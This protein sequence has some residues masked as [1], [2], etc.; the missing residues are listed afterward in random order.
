M[1]VTGMRSAVFMR[2]K[3]SNALAWNWFEPER[4]SAF[5]TEVPERAYSGLKV[6]V[7][8]LNS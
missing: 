3:N 7:S 1:G 2:V 6:L 8:N 4:E 5:I